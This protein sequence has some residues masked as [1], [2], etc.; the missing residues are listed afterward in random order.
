MQLFV[1]L[2]ATHRVL[3]LDELGLISISCCWI[4]DLELFT[5]HH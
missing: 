2:P 5:S 1:I 4:A 3:D